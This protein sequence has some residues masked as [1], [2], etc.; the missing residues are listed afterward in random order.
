MK[1]NIGGLKSQVRI[2]VPRISPNQVDVHAL[3]HETPRS[4]PREAHKLAAQLLDD[5]C[6]ALLCSLRNSIC[7]IRVIFWRVNLPE[8]TEYL[9]RAR[10]FLH[11][12]PGP[13]F[14]VSSGDE[15][16]WRQMSRGKRFR[17]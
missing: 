15:Q 11:V 2:F 10:C 12:V 7:T 4:L 3:R 6:S 17:C 13:R 1:T 5:V 8:H 16:R 9:A 14:D